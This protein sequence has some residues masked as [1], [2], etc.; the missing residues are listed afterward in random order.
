MKIKNYNKILFCG[1]GGSAVPGEIIKSLNLRKP[2]LIAREKLPASVNS[3]TL[4]FVV[5]YSGNTK[6]TIQLYR[7]AKKKR[8][9]IIIITSGGKLGKARDEKMF[10]SKGILPREAYVEMLLPILTA[11]SIKS[12]NLLKIIKKVK[13]REVKKVAKKLKNKFPLV[14]ASS[15][16]LKII[17]DKWVDDFNENAKV[18]AHGG[19]FPEISHNEIEAKAGKNTR[20]IL[21]LDKETK[22]IKKAK[23][24]FKPIVI[25]LK[26][27]NLL[28]KI[29]YGIKLGDLASLYLA[30]LLKRD[31]KTTKRIDYLKG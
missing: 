18:L 15:E 29:I 30:E 8:A 9:K 24:F 3:K 1:I 27:K 23:K 4:C 2:V 10:V 11:L 21:L 22:Q 13:K 14:Y 26:G 28:E 12:T 5:S 25:K 17:S 19:Y 20:V 7:Q 6:E 16:G 31:Y